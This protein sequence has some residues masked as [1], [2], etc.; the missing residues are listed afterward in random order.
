MALPVNA[1]WA[2]LGG[3]RHVMRDKDPPAGLFAEVWKDAADLLWRMRLSC[4][5]EKSY[6]CL[7][8]ADGKTA[9][10]TKHLAT[11]DAM[12]LAYEIR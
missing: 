10:E 8:L 1:E 4:D 7:S 5:Y 3:D 12:D 11:Y 9:A 2:D 6:L